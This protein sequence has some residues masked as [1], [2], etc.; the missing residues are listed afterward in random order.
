MTLTVN[1]FFY[2]STKYWYCEAIF[3]G[4]DLVSGEN[5]LKEP[6][7]RRVSRVAGLHSGGR[8]DPGKLT[9]FGYELLAGT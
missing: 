3:P 9:L 6:P 4:L 5:S 7:A 1:N 8:I 2:F